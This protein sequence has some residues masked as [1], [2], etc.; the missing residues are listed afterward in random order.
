MLTVPISLWKLTKNGE[1]CSCL[2][3]LGKNPSALEKGGKVSVFG[4]PVFCRSPPPQVLCLG[5]DSFQFLRFFASLLTF[6]RCF[7]PASP[8]CQGSRVQ[9]HISTYSLLPW[10]D[11]WARFPAISASTDPRSVYLTQVL[12]LFQCPFSIT[13]EGQFRQLIPHVCQRI[14][15][16]L[17]VTLHI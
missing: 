2:V 15:T 12:S 10:W 17:K 11:S 8:F 3:M 5:M 13:W 4:C 16:T 14:H 6:P 9:K 1:V 7:F